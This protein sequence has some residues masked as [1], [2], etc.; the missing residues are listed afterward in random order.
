MFDLPHNVHVLS[1]GKEKGVPT[2]RQVI[3]FWHLAGSVR[4]DAALI[5]MTPIWVVLGWP[6]WV[7]RKKPA[8]LWYEA[9]GARWPLRVALMIVKKVFSAS[10][11]GMPVAT[12]KSVI[13]GHGIDIDKFAPNSNLPLAPGL[14]VRDNKLVTVGRITASKQLPV[15]IRCFEELSPK[16]QKLEILGTPITKEDKKLKQLLDAYVQTH[17]LEGRV[18]IEALEQDF[19][20]SRLKTSIVFLHASKTGLDKA[21]LEAM[22]CGCIVVSSAEAFKNVLPPECVCTDETMAETVRKILEMPEDQREALRSKL[23]EIVVK[24]HGLPRLIDL[25]VKEMNG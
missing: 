23:R 7:F 18:I 5:H 4:Y 20:L 8:Y 14:E 12:D 3:R 21:P 24:D 15:I 11:A 1:L 10:K 13:T 2:W 25:L 19:L 17:R 22:A 16:I 9:R 6:V